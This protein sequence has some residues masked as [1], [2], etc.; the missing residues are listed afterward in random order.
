MQGFVFPRSMLFSKK[1]LILLLVVILGAHVF[2]MID[3]TYFHVRWLDIPMHFV[4]GVWVA[5]TV[6]A[7]WRHHIAVPGSVN[8]YF[9]ISFLFILG[10]TALVGVLWEYFEFFLDGFFPEREF[11]DFENKWSDTLLDLL[12]DIFGAVVVGIYFLRKSLRTIV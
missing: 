3:K 10:V 11:V 6:A 5:A 12:M 7:F 4:G 1:F 9:L 8:R 2:F